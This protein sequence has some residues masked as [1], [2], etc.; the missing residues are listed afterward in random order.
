MSSRTSFRRPV[1]SSNKRPPMPYTRKERVLHCWEDGPRTDDGGG[2]TC[3]L[4]RDHDGPHEWT[5]D[6]Q[7]G[8]KFAPVVQP[9][10]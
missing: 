10:E 6:D 7:I 9:K 8:I 2:S 5:P 3:M 1:L 4:E